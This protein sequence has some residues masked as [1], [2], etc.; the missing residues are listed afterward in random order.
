MTESM[1][2]TDAPKGAARV[3]RWAVPLAMIVVGV[4][5]IVISN[6]TVLTGI[7]VAVAAGS[8]VVV[9]AGWFGRLGNDKERVREQAARDEYART[10]RWPD[11]D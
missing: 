7:G 3:V 6:G 11:K 2:T 4:A 10:G 8:V 5:L 9:F 1:L